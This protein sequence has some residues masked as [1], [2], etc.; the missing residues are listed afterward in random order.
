MIVNRKSKQ[1]QQDLTCGDG[2]DALPIN[3]FWEDELQ[4]QVQA[5]KQKV[6]CNATRAGPKKK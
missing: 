5:I 2:R 1:V 6:L 3:F 4:V